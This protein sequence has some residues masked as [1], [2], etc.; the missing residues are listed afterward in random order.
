MNSEAQ[1]ERSPV[2]LLWGEDPFVLREAALQ[3]LG[4]L[5]PTE[6]DAADWQGSEL[7]DLSTP[8]LFGEPRALLVTDCRS[9]PKE[10]LAAL[11]AYL[12]A[13]DSAS[14]LVLCCTTAER[15][16]VPAALQKLVEPVGEVR[17]VQVG[18]KD[19]E[20]WLVARASAGDSELSGPGARAL[21]DVIGADAGQ[22]AAGLQQLIDAYPGRRITPAE[23]HAQFRGLGEQKTWDLCDRAFA[24]DLPGAIRSLRSIEE[25]GDDALMVLGGIAARLRDLLKVRSLPDSLPPA[26]VAKEAGLRFEW[27]AR[28]Y[29]QQARNYSMDDLV[30]LHERV[31]EA[32]RALKSGAS[33]TVVMPVLIAAIAA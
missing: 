15:G 29:Q 2:L 12:S 20:P 9:L 30:T 11:A 25:A 26:R 8:S 1:R 6:V 13:P 23:V 5:R 27:Q 4:G 14:P 10:A 7:Q 16:K 22:L 33:G 28:R 17:Q 21:V 31:G 19:V 24:K 3:H 32:D 18:R